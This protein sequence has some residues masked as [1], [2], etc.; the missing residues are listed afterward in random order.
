MGWKAKGGS[1]RGFSPLLERGLGELALIAAAVDV[2]ARLEDLCQALL[3]SARE[4]VVVED[5]VLRAAV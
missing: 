1:V 3:G 5:V 4:V 2:G